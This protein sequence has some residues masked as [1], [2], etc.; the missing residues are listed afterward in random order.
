MIYLF[1]DKKNRQSDYGWSKE[2]LGKYVEHLIPIYTYD[3]ITVED[4]TEIFKNGN[5]IIFHE[6]F[7]DNVNIIHKTNSMDIRKRLNLFA[8]ENIEFNLIV[9]SGSKNSRI[10]YK[11]SASLPVSIMYQNLEIFIKKVI[12]GDLNLEYILFGENIDLEKKLV[13]NFR[14]LNLTYNTDL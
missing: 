6:S 4:R 8:E 14:N 12:E 2:K 9:F 10:I 13:E 7:F 1:D 3:Q 11:N 5:T